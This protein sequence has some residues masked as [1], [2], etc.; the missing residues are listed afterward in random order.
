MFGDVEKIVDKYVKP[1]YHGPT[2]KKKYRK[3][4]GYLC[5]KEHAKGKL[6]S[7]KCK[8]TVYYGKRNAWYALKRN[9]ETKC[10]NRVFGDPLR[11]TVKECRCVGRGRR[12]K[13]PKK[14]PRL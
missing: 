1:C 4:K 6:G 7:C 10:S 8:G 5:A 14:A 3:S 11:G 9:G 13:V 12:Y 2:P